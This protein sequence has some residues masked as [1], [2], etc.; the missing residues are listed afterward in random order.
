MYAFSS[1][2]I[3][4]CVCSGI[5]IVAS[6]YSLF[7]HF[8]TG[9][10]RAHRGLSQQSVNFARTVIANYKPHMHKGPAFKSNTGFIFPHIKRS[11]VLRKWQCQSKENVYIVGFGEMIEDAYDDWVR[12]MFVE[13][14]KNVRYK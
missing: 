6:S 3:F 13:C 1:L 11:R 5:I 2:Y 14:L 12:K 7:C 8:R 9:K 10:I 4:V